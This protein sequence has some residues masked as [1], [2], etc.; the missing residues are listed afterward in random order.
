MTIFYIVF[1][2]QYLDHFDHT[3]E[4]KEKQEKLI[5]V[6]EDPESLMLPFQI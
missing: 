2:R 1:D 6:H 3:G 4:S 5:S